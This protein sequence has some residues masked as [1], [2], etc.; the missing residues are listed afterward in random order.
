MDENNLCEFSNN[1]SFSG[2]HYLHEGLSIVMFSR[3]HC[4]TSEFCHI[5]RSHRCWLIFGPNILILWHEGT[6]YSGAKLRYMVEAD[7]MGQ[8]A[9]ILYSVPSSINGRPTSDT[10]STSY[11]KYFIIFFI[12]ERRIFHKKVDAPQGPDKQMVPAFI[13]W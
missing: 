11:R 1:P 12:A 4:K 8:V 13:G 6:L 3:T 5:H 2:I 10:I 9:T 7:D